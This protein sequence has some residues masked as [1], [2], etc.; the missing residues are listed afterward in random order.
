ML[1]S[2]KNVKCTGSEIELKNDVRDLQFDCLQ[3]NLV[4]TSVTNADEQVTDQTADASFGIFFLVVAVIGVMVC[5]VVARGV[6]L[7]VIDPKVALAAGVVLVVVCVGVAIVRWVVPAVGAH[8]SEHKFIYMTV[9]IVVFV[10]AAAAAAYRIYGA[11]ARSPYDGYADDGRLLHPQQPYAP[12]LP[13]RALQAPPPMHGHHGPAGPVPQPG[14]PQLPPQQ[15]MH[16]APARPTLAQ[17]GHHAMQEVA[18]HSASRAP[19]RMPQ[20]LGQRMSPGRGLMRNLTSG[21]RA[22]APLGAAVEPPA[23]TRPT[24]TNPLP[25]SVRRRR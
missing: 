5:V 22:A 6:M 24:T 10:A 18:H 21:A 14:A 17:A 15:V 4:D 13:P 20:S 11:G 1:N 3:R 25:R 16:P 9:M 19:A 12:A 7:G 23:P 8:L 2:F